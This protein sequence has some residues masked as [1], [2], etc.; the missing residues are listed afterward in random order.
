MA[1]YTIGI[2]FGTLSV[3]AL[4][5]NLE[6]GEEVACS[7]YVYPHAINNIDFNG[8]KLPDSFALQHPDDYVDGLKS[9]IDGVMKKLG[10]GANDVKGLGID[11]TSCTVIAVDENNMPMCSH[12]E[13]KF[14]PHAFVKLWKHH[15]AQKQ[16]DKMTEVAKRLNEDW[17]NKYGGK[18]SSE[19]FFPKVLETFENAPDLFNKTAKFLEAGEWIV[20]LITGT[21]VLSSCMQGFKSNWNETKG[22]PSKEF[23]SEINPE[24]AHVIYDKIKGD[25]KHVEKCAGKINECGAQITG[26]KQGTA[27]SVAVIDAHSAAPS[28]GVVESGKLLLILGT[29]ACHIALSSK[30]AEI[31][32]IC[33][34]AKDSVVEGLYAYEAGQ[35]CFGDVFDWF[36]NNCLP[37]DYIS[38]AKEKGVGIF[39]YLNTLSQSLEVGQNGL[40]ALDWWNGNRTPYADFDVKGLILGLDL[41]TKPEHIYRALLESNAFG[42]RRIIEIYNQAGLEIKEIIAGGGIAVKN[43]HVMQILADVLGME[44]KVVDSKQAGA[45]GS[46]IYAAVACGE[47]VNLKSASAVLADKCNVCYKPNN[48]NKKAYDKLY[49]EYLVLSE[50]FAKANSVMKTI[51]EHN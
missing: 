20:Q 24:F 21:N 6:N 19:W 33:G 17:L 11:F 8:R 44:I 37:S 29:S 13:F 39:D 3:R 14:E 18:V 41:N 35:T 47:F 15:G 9:V 49:N 34:V 22:Y 36:K 1:K 26:L 51:R 10:V 30:G 12:A 48:E 2:D 23:F 27:V 40:L 31:E 50:Y 38:N 25:I 46:C 43:P 16:A 45:K 7:E 28:T 42:T 5:L 32:G 4:L